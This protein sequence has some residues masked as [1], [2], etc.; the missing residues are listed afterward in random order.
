MIVNHFAWQQFF[1]SMFLLY[2]ILER[3]ATDHLSTIRF[4]LNAIIFLTIFR[5]TQNNFFQWKNTDN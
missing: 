3:L 5:F 2:L 1:I 4:L